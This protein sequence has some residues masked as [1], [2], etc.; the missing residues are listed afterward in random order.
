MFCFKSLICSISKV[1]FGAIINL[2]FTTIVFVN[3]SICSICL[4][5]KWSSP[6]ILLNLPYIVNHA[7]NFTRFVVDVLLV[8]FNIYFI[9]SKKKIIRRTR[10]RH[11]ITRIDI[12]LCQV[13]GQK[14]FIH[15]NRTCIRKF[16]YSVPMIQL[17][18]FSKAVV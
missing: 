5:H 12:F 18:I 16:T 2:Q 8:L 14:L 6:L 1:L 3:I 10:I 9:I 4:I 15:W 13:S 17:S 11:R 7:R